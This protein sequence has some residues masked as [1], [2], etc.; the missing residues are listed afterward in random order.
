MPFWFLIIF[1]LPGC[2][3]LPKKARHELQD[4]YY[5]KLFSEKKWVYIQFAED[6]ILVYPANGRKQPLHQNKN[7]ILQFPDIVNDQS[8]GVLRLRQPSL[9][10]DF[11]TIPLKFRG[12][13]A[14]VPPQLNANLNGAL[15][16]GY[17]NDFFK[18]DY[19]PTPL[20]T[21]KRQIN[22]FGF[23]TGI[24]TGIGNTFISPT[25]TDFR[26]DQEYDGIVW[27][28]G[29]AGIIAFGNFTA[30]VTFGLDHL[31]DRNK[32]IWIYQKRVWFGLGFGLNIN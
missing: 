26:I 3:V 5:Q 13:T 9:D 19:S 30:G 7:G 6:T 25:N 22:H 16:V 29:V 20:H 21:A 28:K 14:N 8:A 11:L 31:L 27:S 24:F 2:A 4:G 15:Y 1:F 10:L 17:R 18:V 12:R 32:N 23:S